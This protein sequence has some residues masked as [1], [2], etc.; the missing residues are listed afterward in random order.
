MIIV[1]LKEEDTRIDE[2]I[3]KSYIKSHTTYVGYTDVARM[4][5]F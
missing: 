4:V 5:T 2:T 1:F 3:E